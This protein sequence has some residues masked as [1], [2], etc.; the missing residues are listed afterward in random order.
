MKN[1][2]MPGLYAL[3]SPIG[4][5]LGLIRGTHLHTILI[6]FKDNKEKGPRIR[7][8]LVLVPCCG[9]KLKFFR[10]MFFEPMCISELY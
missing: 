2:V 10:N 1:P 9:E 4:S 6:E 7:E 3:V 5:G 8:I